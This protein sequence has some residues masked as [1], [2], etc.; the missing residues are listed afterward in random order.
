MRPLKILHISDT[1]GKH[2]ELGNLP[3]ADVIVHSGD[4]TF[5]GSDG[6]ALDF[7][8]WFC[9]L[10]YK[11][12]IFIAGNHDDCMMDATLDGLPEGVHY[13]A[14]SEVCI[15]GV[16]FYG[17]PMFCGKK[18]VIERCGDI[19]NNVDVLITHRPPL[20]ILDG[21]EENHLGSASILYKVNDILP[22]IHL[23]GH[24]HNGYGIMKWKNIVFSNASMVDEGYIIT[25]TA[26]LIDY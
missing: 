8:E 12:K 6:E 11:Y 4:F 3:A 18:Q 24:A 9:N 5:G 7:M 22:R 21:D 2:R 1:H 23:F 19:P 13:L 15:E 17:V 10:P 16:H 14:D 20:D 25:N 26:R